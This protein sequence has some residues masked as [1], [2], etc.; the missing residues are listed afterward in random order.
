[1]KRVYVVTSRNQSGT[2]QNELGIY[3]SFNKA[4]SAAKACMLYV[5]GT[6]EYNHQELHLDDK[7]GDA[8]WVG[9]LPEEPYNYMGVYARALDERPDFCVEHKGTGEILTVYPANPYITNLYE[10]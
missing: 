9:D 7:R 8:G 5:S 6:A 3:S 4:H 10:R 1:V 2:E